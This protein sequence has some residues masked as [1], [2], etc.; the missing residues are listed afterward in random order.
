MFPQFGYAT[1]PPPPCPPG[2]L[3][4]QG[5]I[6]ADHTYG[7][8]EG[9][10]KFFFLARVAP[11]PTWAVEHPNTILEPNLDSDAIPTLSLLLTPHLTLTRTEYWDRAGGERN[12]TF[13]AFCDFRQAKIAYNGLKTGPFH[14]FMHPKRFSYHSGKTPFDPFLTLFG[15]P[16][17]HFQGFLGLWSVIT[18]H[19]GLKTGQKHLFEHPKWSRNKSGKKDFGPFLDPQMTHVTLP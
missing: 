15:H 4:Y 14:L 5:S 17:A 9:A 16:K 8:A 18:G 11:L 7:G 12:I 6:A 2:P 3:S 13:K 19:H 1:P 10:Q